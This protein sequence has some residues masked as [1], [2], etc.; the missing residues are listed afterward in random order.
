MR[1]G[2]NYEWYP[3]KAT[4]H[5]TFVE[6]GFIR[7]EDYTRTHCAKVVSQMLRNLADSIEKHADHDAF[8]TNP[9]WQPA[10]GEPICD[11]IKTDLVGMSF[12]GHI[13][14][15]PNPEYNYTWDLYMALTLDFK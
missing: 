12:V 1:Q 3:D 11:P 8:I 5:Q 15:P 2:P 9:K 10:P 14:S 6:K 13:D 7:H 4:K